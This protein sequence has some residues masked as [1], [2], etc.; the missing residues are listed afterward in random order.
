MTVLPFISGFFS[1]ISMILLEV[2]GVVVA[3][4]FSL[5]VSRVRFVQR[6]FVPEIDQIAQVD[7]RA[8]LEF[9]ESNIKATRD[10]T[11]VLIFVS[12]FEHRAVVLA[13]KS[14][15]DRFPPNT[16]TEIMDGLLA[17]IKAGDMAGGFAWA[18][19]RT[20]ELVSPYFPVKAGDRNELANDL[21]IKN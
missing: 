12:L 11:G 16:W 5:F 2:G 9:F 4:V 18:I 7:D 8:E 21:I 6:L 20:G 14:I 13:D 3:F 10:S 15:A 19:E 17:K 1:S